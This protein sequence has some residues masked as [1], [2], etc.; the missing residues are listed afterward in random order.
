MDTD[1]SYEN[2]SEAGEEESSTDHGREVVIPHGLEN[3]LHTNTTSRHSD[4]KGSRRKRATET[5]EER[6]QRLQSH[7]NDQYLNLL[8]ESSSDAIDGAQDDFDCT[9]IGLT[10]WSASEKERLFRALSR[11][12][13]VN[14][15]GIAT[16]IQSKSE[17]ETY[18]YLRLLEEEATNRHLFAEE[19]HNAGH[20]DISAATEV[21][22]ECEAMLEKAADALTV[23]QDRFD[24]AL[25][26][27]VHHDGWLV[28]R[29]QAE[30]YDQLVDAAEDDDHSSDDNALRNRRIPAEGLFRL[31]SWLSLTERVFMNSDPSR[32]DNNWSIHAAEDEVPAITQGA[33]S[34]L[35]H[36]ALYKLRK[37]MQT[38][39]FCAESR[40]RSTTDHGY[41]VKA[42][43]KEEDVASAINLL[44]LTEDRSQ[45]WLC[46]ARRNH[47]KVVYDHRKKGQSR[48]KRLRYDEIERMLS[49]SSSMR[50]RRRSVPSASES[51]S[52]CE[53]SES[54]EEGSNS[55][56]TIGTDFV[57]SDQSAGKRSFK[58]GHQVHHLSRRGDT[59]ILTQHTNQESDDSEPS[60]TSSEE[61]LSN[62]GDEQDRILETLD[63]IN[64]RRI[65]LQMYHDLGWAIA[66]SIKLCYDEELKAQEE[67][68]P[69]NQRKIR[70][71]LQDWRGSISGYAESWEKHGEVVNEARFVENQTRTKRRR[72]DQEVGKQQDLPFRTPPTRSDP[73]DALDTAMRYD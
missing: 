49:E 67:L 39:I 29:V 56:E 44:G 4:F 25:G 17:L 9:Q 36:L 15:R 24:Q 46:L 2:H 51:L 20:A 52:L 69:M 48:K 50:R 13:K 31:S 33:I 62:D 12:S 45:F 11:N 66:G 1:F 65:E 32:N 61:D 26:G 34:D 64:S 54:V 10:S 73:I 53:D 28:D 16:S 47:L 27:R 55:D 68:V 63:Q 42:L 58:Q 21:S 70:P 30:A 41:T 60:F 23:Y 43:V 7:Y 5:K 59:R 3:S 19:V 71:D 72:I 37:V 35:Y 40:I 18:N 22:I 14:V 57:T 38:S 6:W 8:N